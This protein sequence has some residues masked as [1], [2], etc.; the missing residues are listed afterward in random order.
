MDSA[1]KSLDVRRFKKAFTLV[2]LLVVISIIALLLSIMLPALN[3]ARERAKRI[4]CGS[5]L[6]QIGIGVQ[7]YS[8]QNNGLIP[9]WCLPVQG[10]LR[11]ITSFGHSVIG[12]YPAP[13]GRTPIGLGILAEGSGALLKSRD[14]F[15]CP[16]D[17]YFATQREKTSSGLGWANF[18]L[19]Y[20][21]TPYYNHMSYYHLYVSKGGWDSTGKQN[22]PKYERYRTVGTP[23][24]SAIT[25]D[26][27]R[28]DPWGQ[29][30]EPVSDFHKPVGWNTLYMDGH[31]NW[32]KALLASDIVR[33]QRDISPND[34]WSVVLN[35]LDGR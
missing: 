31:V 18:K 25:M 17:R 12:S 26:P 11:P 16:S 21:T 29:K 3:S 34:Y 4:Q 35:Y 30:Y 20:P 5:N 13:F 14:L 7:T 33:I 27:G 24:K 32:G 10:S 8:V 6:R 2:E 9:S 22:Y 15:F 1:S 19:Y 23:S 28:D